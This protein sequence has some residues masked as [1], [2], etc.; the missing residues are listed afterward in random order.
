MQAY[1]EAVRQASALPDAKGVVG[2]V[3]G[4]GGEKA[5]VDGA[6]CPQG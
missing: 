6:A 5:G 3:K 1:E 2:T 4:E